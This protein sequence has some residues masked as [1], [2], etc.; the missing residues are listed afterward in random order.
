MCGTLVKGRV[1]RERICVNQLKS[2]LILV[3]CA[4]LSAFRAQGADVEVLR[5]R[6]NFYVI[7]GAGGNIGVQIGVNGVV[8]VD[9]GAAGNSAQVLA[10]IRKLTDKPIRYIINTSADADHVGGNAELAKA[11]RSIYTAEGNQAA[12]IKAMTGGAASIMA[13]ENVL[14]RMS[15]P[16]GKVAHFPNDAW[17]SET[18]SADYRN[19]YF[20]GEGIEVLHQPA[21]NSD[22]DSMVFFR[23]SDV[24]MAGS[25]LD[26][27]RFPAIHVEEGGSI[28]GEIDA[29]NRLIRLAIPPGPFVY[30][31][32]GTFVIPGIG[33]ICDQA[34][35]VEYRDM[36]VIVRDVVKDMMQHGMTLDQIKAAS[37]AKPYEKEY[38]SPSGASTNEFIEAIYKS[39]A[40][41]K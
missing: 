12:F 23:I 19:F 11:G 7:A 10:G 27:A 41:K 39:L 40:A 32:G 37:P 2:T 36:V 6:P 9:S 18:F 33:R 13:H 34:D 25:I 8:L 31:K 20:N 29:L 15:A 30:E 14:L 3:A 21:A 22:G 5:V 16:T 26:T 4:L 35:V 24:V 28:Q 38:G 1:L 17:P